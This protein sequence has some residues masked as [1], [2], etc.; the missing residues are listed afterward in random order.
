MRNPA[1]LI[2]P[3][4]FLTTRAHS[5]T[6]APFLLNW[7]NRGPIGSVFLAYEANRSPA[8][9]L[10]LL[11]PTPLVNAS[12]ANL[13]ILHGQAL[14]FWDADGL[15]GPHSAGD[16][17][18]D[19]RHIPPF[20]QR[21]FQLVLAAG[22]RVGVT[23]RAD[24]DYVGHPENPEHFSETYAD[25]L[26]V[27]RAKIA[28]AKAMGVSVFYCDSSV[29]NILDVLATV[30][31][32]NPD[33]LFIPELRRPQDFRWGATYMEFSDFSYTTTNYAVNPHAFTVICVVSDFPDREVFPRH[34]DEVI[35]RLKKGDV[36]LFRAW[37]RSPEFVPLYKALKEAGRP[38][39]PL[40]PT[41][42][43]EP[44]TT[45]P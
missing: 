8:N 36:P 27:T 41:A 4:L 35:E 34:H 44:P 29:G 14:I 23:L 25:R 31:A 21:T 6:T 38:V 2:L 7:P 43:Q 11:N 37:Y 1:T 19:P 45:K 39:V 24:T 22:L 12:I 33:C 5:Q 10:G 26:A 30:A 3:L 15:H 13:K 16:Y 17:K 42:L 18:G 32:E 28:A 20:V 9:P 40:N